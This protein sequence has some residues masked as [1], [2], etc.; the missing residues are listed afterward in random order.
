MPHIFSVNR[1]MDDRSCTVAR[2]RSD[3]KPLHQFIISCSNKLSI[4]LCGHTI[5]AD[6][7]NFGYSRPV[8]LFSIS[9]L[10][11]P[12]DRMRGC[13]LCQC[14]IFQKLLFFHFTMMNTIYLKYAFGQCTG[15]VKYNIFCLRHCL[16]I[17]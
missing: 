9:T 11:A 1:N 13:T 5:S 8:D 10:D 12:A 14:R 4:H 15:L 2:N 17:I 3:S 6:L 16:K 7:L